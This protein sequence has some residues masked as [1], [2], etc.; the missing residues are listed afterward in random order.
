M[1][2]VVTDTSKY[3]MILLI[4]L[5]TFW[6][7]SYLR[8]ADE[9]HQKR[10]S[11]L[12]NTVMFIL[13]FLGFLILYGKTEDDRMI[14]LY[15]AEAVL[16]AAFLWLNRLFY[17]GRSRIL[18]NNIC[19]LLCA[20]FII[21]AR[22]SFDKAVRQFIIVA[23]SA[24][25]TLLI[26]L[27]IDHLWQ[28]ALIPWVYGIIG[29]LLLTLVLFVGTST[30]GALLSFSIGGLS[31]QPS[32]F[33]KI[34]FVFFIASMLCRSTDR[35]TLMITAA[36][37]AAH[38]IVLVLC[39]DLGGALI[40]FV[41]TVVMFYV[42]TSDTFVLAAGALTG[43]VAAVAA[44]RLFSHVQNRVAAWL[45]PWSDINNTGYQI[46]QSLFAIGTGGWF[47]LGLCQGMPERVPVVEKDFIF[48]AI[49]E[50]MGG[51]FA[52]CILLICVG[53]F[54]QFMTIA[55]YMDSIFYKLVAFG[56]G[57]EYFLQVILAVGGVIKFI[58]ST[59]VTLP[60]ISYGGSSILSTFILFE[61]IQGLYLLE[62]S[63][64]KDTDDDSDYGPSGDE[65]EDLGDDDEIEFE[66]DFW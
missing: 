32:E 10:I 43:G 66:E 24:F 59:G 21:L 38:V 47:G 3:I 65:Y 51:I 55:S 17:P 60:F 61:V 6:N 58:P 57:I 1:L 44:W 54:L 48:A 49:S 53:C 42:A 26:P 5:Y 7:F 25:I 22:L 37:A 15:L 34:S 52:I 11:F 29:L 9:R 50:E 20:G 18:V 2:N 19:L 41:T 62:K 46:A 28:L 27:I 56:L 36:M 39:R 16:L 64:G 8:K 12:Q 30:Y 31:F 4:A 63:G 14:L 23:V 40:F 13:H 35:K 33:V 45:D